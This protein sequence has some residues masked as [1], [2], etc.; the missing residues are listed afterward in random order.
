MFL[1]HVDSC[2]HD[3]NGQNSNTRSS[4]VPSVSVVSLASRSIS[5]VAGAARAIRSSGRPFAP[6][7]IV[8]MST[9]KRGRGTNG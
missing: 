7:S 1:L 3:A 8:D 6:A 5:P 9:G 2:R 4:S